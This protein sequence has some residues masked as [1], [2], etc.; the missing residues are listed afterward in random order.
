MR[1][2]MNVCVFRWVGDKEDLGGVVQGETAVRMHCTKIILSMR[3]SISNQNKLS[4][5]QK[6]KIK[7]K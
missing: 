1:E 4:K 7:S 3:K 2:S 6:L 5:K